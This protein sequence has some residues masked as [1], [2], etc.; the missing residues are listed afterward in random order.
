MPG[1]H[2]G[3]RVTDGTSTQDYEPCDY[4]KRS[5]KMDGVSFEA[6]WVCAPNGVLGR[7][8]MPEDVAAG[9]TTQA[10]YVEELEDGH[11]SVT[12]QE[13]NS[14]S[15]KVSDGQSEWHGYIEHGVWKSVE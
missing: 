12:P 4:G 8:S 9:R 11:I 10:H 6:W 13:G 7:L 1:V 14:N 15:I 5:I 2:A 3:R